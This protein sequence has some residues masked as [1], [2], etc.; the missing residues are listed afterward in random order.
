MERALDEFGGVQPLILGGHAEI[1]E[2]IDNLLA[3]FAE[4]GSIRLQA[5]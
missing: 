2:E 3:D 4:L 1:N 5:A